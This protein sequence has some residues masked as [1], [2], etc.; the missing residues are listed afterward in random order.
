MKEVVEKRGRCR[1]SNEGVGSFKRP[2]KALDMQGPGAITHSDGKKHWPV[3]RQD[4]PRCF[5]CGK[6]TRPGCQK[7]EI[8]LCL[9]TKELLVVISQKNNGSF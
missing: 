9:M 6:K 8:G 7:C 5:L 4:K 1:P 3:H 2:R